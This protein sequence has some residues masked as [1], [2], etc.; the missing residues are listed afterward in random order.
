M[1]HLLPPT[2]HPARAMFDIADLVAIGTR[3]RPPIF[4]QD[5]KRAARRTFAAN[6]AIRRLMYIIMRSD[7][8]AL[9]LISVGPRGG[10][11]VEW[12]F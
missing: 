5:A 11:R 3:Q 2:N 8:D 1:S 6:T 10:H 12:R 4:L 9:E 7:T